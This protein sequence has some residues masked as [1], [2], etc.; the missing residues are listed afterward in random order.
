MIVNFSRKYE[1]KAQSIVEILWI[2]DQWINYE[3]WLNEIPQI[4]VNT[5]QTFETSSG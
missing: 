5:F 1:V 3:T 2:D 4:E